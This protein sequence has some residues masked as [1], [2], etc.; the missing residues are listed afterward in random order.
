MKKTV[1]VIGHKN[2]DTDSGVSAAAYA[3]LKK[4]MGFDNFVA[5]RAGHF[6]PQTEYIFTRVK[7]P[8]PEYVP[9]LIPKTAYYMRDRCHTVDYHTPLLEAIGKMDAKSY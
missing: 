1:Y 5:A 2:P 4:L 3:R 9:D 7:V 6:S 8:V